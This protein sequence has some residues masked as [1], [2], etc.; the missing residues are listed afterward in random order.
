MRALRA[1]PAREAPGAASGSVAHLAESGV[2]LAAQLASAIAGPAQ[3]FLCLAQVL[4][5]AFAQGISCK[6][7]LGR[8]PPCAAPFLNQRHA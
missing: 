6:A 4:R 7:E 3:P 8:M 5:R 1:Q 2:F